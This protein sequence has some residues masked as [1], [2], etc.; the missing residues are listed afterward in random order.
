MSYGSAQS[1]QRRAQRQSAAVQ[2]AF[3]SA[4]SAYPDAG[5]A[6]QVKE[7]A[8]ASRVSIDRAV[9]LLGF[10]EEGTVTDWCDYDTNAWN[11]H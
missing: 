3:S 11:L 5:I 2:R 7:A 9:S 6:L 1:Q 4:R 8:K 10:G